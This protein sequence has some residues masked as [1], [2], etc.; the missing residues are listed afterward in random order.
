MTMLLDTPQPRPARPAANTLGAYA[1]R[2]PCTE[3]Q[4]ASFDGAPIFYR[5]WPATAPT[6]TTR[7]VLLLHRGHE[8]GGRMAHLVDEFDLPA[9]DFFA[10][11]MRGLGQSP[12]ARGAAESFGVLVKDADA[13]LRH[14][15]PAHGVAAENAVVVAQSFGAALAATWVHDYAPRLR[16]LVLAAPAFRINLLVPGA[17]QGLQLAYALRGRFFVNSYV[18]PTQLTQDPARVAS[19]QADK[20]ITRPIAVNV[21]LDVAEASRRVVADAAAIQVP[22]QVLVSGADEVV[23]EQP[24]RDFYERLGAADKEC[25]R[26][27]DLRH[28]TLGELHRARPIGLARAFVQR[29]FAAAAPARPS[30]LAADQHGFTQAEYERLRQPARSP[31]ARAYWAL[32]RFWIRVGGRL[33][34]G[35][36]GGL[37]TGFDSGSS[38]DYVYRNQAQGH[39]VLGRLVDKFYLNSIGWRGIRLRKLNVE[40]MLH[41]AFA[42]LHAAGRPVRVLDVA[43]GHGRY[44]LDALASARQPVAQVLLRDFSADNVAAGRQL[45]AARNVEAVAKFEQ[46]DAF[47]AAS[48]AAVRPQPTVAVVSGLY[49]LFPDNQSVQQSLAGLA[50]AVEPGGYLVYTNQPWHPQL[51]LIAR[52]LSSHRH[53]GAWVMRRRIQAEMDELVAAAGFEKID[54]LSDQWG[55]FSVSLARRV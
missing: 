6:A 33:S 21:L 19:Y 12:G 31:L 18:K 30:L 51:E 37:Q 48:L 49:E 29:Q 5:H 55:I 28:D 43:A 10:W 54:Q 25:H 13:W 27:P 3:H 22:T 52:S 36:A 11:D 34:A 45:I 17:L 8:H 20:L 4:F 7:A 35:I 50:E 46:G 32:S 2:R 47:D 38:L 53:G 23:Y 26:L 44:V 16:G 24:Q 41:A 1:T 40:A 39:T 9:C 14:L 42:Q 15:A